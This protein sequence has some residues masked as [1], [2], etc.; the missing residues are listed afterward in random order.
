[1]TYRSAILDFQIPQGLCIDVSSRASSNFSTSYSL[2]SEGY[3][4][5]SF[6]YLFSSLPLYGLDGSADVNLRDIVQGYVQIQELRTPRHSRWAL[7]NATRRESI[8]YGRMFLPASSIEALYMRRLNVSQQ[9]KLSFVSD[10]RLKNQGTILAQLQSDVGKY[11]TEV[12]FSTDEALIGLRGLY[13]FGPDPRRPLLPPVGKEKYGRLSAGAEVYYGV[14]NKSGGM[15]TGIRFSTLPAHT[16]TP[17]TM[18]LT[19]NPLIGS[20]S[21]TYAVRAGKALTFCSRLGFNVYSYESDLAMGFELWRMK[22]GALSSQVPKEI[23]IDFK[24]RPESN[25]PATFLETY[26]DDGVLPQNDSTIAGVC[27]ARIDQNLR[28]GLVW[29]GKLKDLL[30]T[31]GSSIDLRRREQP[32]QGLGIQIQYCS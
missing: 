24:A 4:H 2:G 29:E 20:L 28:I 14:L 22:Q 19:V 6:A 16:G 23:D 18:T 15:S 3:V 10:E 1:V 9:L 21:S 30:F 13:N 27:R 11:S 7:Q 26:P 8:L 32:F 12:L 5:G 31:L 25:D 17:L